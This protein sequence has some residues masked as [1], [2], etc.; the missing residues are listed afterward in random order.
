M[1]TG[2]DSN[3]KAFMERHEVPQDVIWA[4]LKDLSTHPGEAVVVAGPHLPA[5]VHG[6]TAL[7]NLAIERAGQ[8]PRLVP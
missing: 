7:L 6:A 2:D 3:L 1:D 5:P 8:D 4:M